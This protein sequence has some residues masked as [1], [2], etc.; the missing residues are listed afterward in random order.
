[1]DNSSKQSKHASPDRRHIK[2]EIVHLA[3]GKDARLQTSKSTYVMWLLTGLTLAA[4]TYIF[5][6]N[7]TPSVSKVALRNTH[8]PE[9]Y[10]ICTEPGKIYTVDASNSAVD[11][12]LVRRDE[13]MASGTLGKTHSLNVLGRELTSS[14]C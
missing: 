10:A 1:M 8:L 9:S 7:D 3:E 14:L 6:P 5:I 4:V 12:I 2:G 13:I 11:C